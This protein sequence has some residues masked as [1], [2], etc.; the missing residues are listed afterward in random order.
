MEQLLFSSFL[1]QGKFQ[2]PVVVIVSSLIPDATL[3]KRFSRAGKRLGI[4]LGQKNQITALIW[5]KIV[6]L[7]FIPRRNG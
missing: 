2:N 6:T 3:S 4:F 5:P 7:I 1:I